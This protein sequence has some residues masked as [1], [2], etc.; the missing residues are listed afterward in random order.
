MIAFFIY[1]PL[2]QYYRSDR[3]SKILEN[4][5]MNPKLFELKQNDNKLRIFVRNID[6]IS[7]AHDV[8]NKLL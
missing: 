8:L 1:N 2:S 3:F 4:I 6:S 5:N 7:K